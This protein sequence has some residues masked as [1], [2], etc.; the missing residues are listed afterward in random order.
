MSAIGKHSK[1][2]HVNLC[3]VLFAPS[4]GKACCKC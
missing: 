3:P 1:H 4:K 2:I